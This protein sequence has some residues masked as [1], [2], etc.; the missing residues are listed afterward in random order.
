MPAYLIA[1]HQVTNPAQFEDYRR[2]VAPLI[3]RFGGRYLTRPGTHEVLDGA[4]RPNR[5]VVIEF[6]DMPTLRARYQSP[7][8]QP[9]IE[10]RRGAAIDLLIAVEGS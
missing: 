4:W 10:L 8:Y 6:P 3:E 1:E 7:D 5:V 9:L 2:Q